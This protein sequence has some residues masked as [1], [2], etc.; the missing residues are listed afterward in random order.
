MAHPRVEGKP[1]PNT[2]IE[3]ECSSTDQ[4]DSWKGRYIP[5]TL[6]PRHKGVAGECATGAP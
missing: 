2:A 3:Q 4:L 5:T 1:V 6:G